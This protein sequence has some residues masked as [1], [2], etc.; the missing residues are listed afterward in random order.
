MMNKDLSFIDVSD[1]VTKA[2]GSNDGIWYFKDRLNLSEDLIIGFSPTNY[3]C[4][5]ISGEHEFHARFSINPCKVQPSRKDNVR[6]ALFFRFRGLP[7]SDLIN[8]QEFLVKMKNKRT[9]SCH[10]GLLQVLSVGLGL[11]I[12]RTK[13][14]KATPK[15][16][17]KTLWQHGLVN[18]NGNPITYEVY[19]SR[20]KTPAM[21]MEDIERIEAKYSWVFWLSRLHFFFLKFY[22][23]SLT[24][25]REV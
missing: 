10:V 9:P 24:V 23:P 18:K 25:R 13:L 2:D 16:F 4:F 17:L 14:E 6:A 7:Q 15:S 1:E 11:T 8:F 20:K 12:P 19:S 5:I 21:I 3:H 22:S